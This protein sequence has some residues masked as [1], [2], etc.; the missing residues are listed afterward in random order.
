MPA[1]DLA[2]VIRVTGPIASPSVKLDTMGAAKT[3][4]AIG[5]VVASGG[6][7]A[8]ATPLLSAGDDPNPCATARAGGKQAATQERAAEPKTRQEDVVRSLRD[9]FKR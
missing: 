2:E 8:L 6:W 3:A 9:L 7:G 1:V 4:L 5:G